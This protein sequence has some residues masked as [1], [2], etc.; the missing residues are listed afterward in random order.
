MRKALEIN[1]SGAHLDPAFSVKF[2]RAKDEGNKVKKLHSVLPERTLG[3][4]LTGMRCPLR[5]SAHR[6]LFN[7]SSDSSSCEW[8]RTAAM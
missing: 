7:T 1:T 5:S 4:K 2:V 3:S 8:V 6:P